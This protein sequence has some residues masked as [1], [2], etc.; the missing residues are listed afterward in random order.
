LYDSGPAFCCEIR[1]DVDELEVVLSSLLVEYTEAL[2]ERGILV[3]ARMQGS[4]TLPLDTSW[5]LLDFNIIAQ[6]DF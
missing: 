2:I 1:C 4:A 5:R 6:L 3:A